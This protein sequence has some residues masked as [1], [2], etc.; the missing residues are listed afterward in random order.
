MP[1]VNV[2]EGSTP[3]IVTEAGPDGDVVTEA[4]RDG[5]VVTE[6][7]RDADVVTEAGRDGDDAQVDVVSDRVV[8]PADG[9]VADAGMCRASAPPQ[10]GQ[11]RHLASSGELVT[12]TNSMTWEPVN[13]GAP[14]VLPISEDFV[15]DVALTL[16]AT[17]FL[18]SV[19]SDAGIGSVG[20]HVALY[21]R[22]A[23]VPVAG[24]TCVNPTTLPPGCN[25]VTIAQ[26]TTFRIRKVM[27]FGVFGQRYFVE[28]DRGCAAPCA[29]DEA[30]C[31]A[32]QTCLRSGYDICTWCDGVEKAICA[33]RD[34]CGN[35]KADATMCAY[36][37]S[38]DQGASGQ[39]RAGRC[40][41]SFQ[42][43]GCSDQ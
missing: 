15:A 6:A 10:C 27:E 14:R 35:A 2:A 24:V 36:D 32:N 43:P 38:D 34:S 26:G 12:A 23:E 1:D 31:E 5:D 41:G 39:C 21:P 4:G 42:S 29:V 33:C 25:G 3:D 9:D 17:T 30:R 7:G 22:K 28:I 40:C 19:G 13:L 20:Y 8:P 16:V 37:I 11:S 18:P